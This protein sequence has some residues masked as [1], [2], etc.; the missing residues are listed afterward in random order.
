MERDELE[1]IEKFNYDFLS[2][3]RIGLDFPV[4]MY[5]NNETH[6]AIIKLLNEYKKLKEKIVLIS[7]VCIDESK[8]HIETSKAIKEI[9]N[10][11]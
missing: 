10:I 1:L 4:T 9:R 11:L 7:E 2:A 3:T 8:L 6:N 5:I